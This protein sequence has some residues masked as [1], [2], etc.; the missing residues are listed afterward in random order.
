[1]AFLNLSY[2]GHGSHG[3][4]LFLALADVVD[5]NQ[6]CAENGE[7]CCVCLFVDLLD[8]I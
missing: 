8:E 7:C 1:M 3:Q 5:P 2:I 6:E 4:Y